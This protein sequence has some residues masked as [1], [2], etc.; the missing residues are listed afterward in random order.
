[1]NRQ[2]FKDTQ[3]A[4]DHMKRSRTPLVT[5]DPHTD[6]N[7]GCTSQLILWG[8]YYPD[9]KTRKRHPMACKEIHRPVSLIHTDKNIPQILAINIQRNRC[10][11]HGSAVTNPTSILKDAGLIP[12]LTQWH[13]SGIAMSCGIGRRWVLDLALLWMWYRPATAA[14]IGPLAWELPYA[15]VE[16]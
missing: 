12:G 5:G 3:M 15:T 6:L 10:F 8:Q 16:L 13:W 2:F 4:N 1:M 14:L 7:C 11:C 9:T